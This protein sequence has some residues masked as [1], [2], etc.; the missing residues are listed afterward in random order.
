MADL[1]VRGVKVTAPSEVLSGQSKNGVSFIVVRILQ[2]RLTRLRVTAAEGLRR[3]IAT[4]IGIN[5]GTTGKWRRNRNPFHSRSA[6]PA[7]PPP[8]P[9]V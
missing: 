9:L 8:P 6:A 2:P 1:A 7:P 5:I 4:G 3:K